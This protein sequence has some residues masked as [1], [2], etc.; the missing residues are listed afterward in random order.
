M[1]YGHLTERERYVISHLH[2]SGYSDREISRRLPRS[3]T[4]ISREVARNKA[5]YTCYWYTYRACR[6]IQKFPGKMKILIQ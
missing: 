4:T 5:P 2:G 6:K 1:L 3:H